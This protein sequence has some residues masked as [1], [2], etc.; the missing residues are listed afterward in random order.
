MLLEK[1]TTMI[2]V[3]QPWL[4]E[5]EE[6]YAIECVRSGWVSSAGRFVDEFEQQWAAY[7]HRAFGVSVNNGTSALQAAIEALDL[8][9]GDEV[10]LPSLT[11]ISCAQCIIQAG[12]TPVLVDCDPETWTMNPQQV[13]DRVTNHT[14]AVMAVHLYGHPVD[15][16]PILELCERHGLALIEDAAQA[17]GAECLVSDTNSDDSK[18]WQRCGSFGAMSCFSFYAN[19][20]ITT[21][22][23]GMVLTN[24][25]HL[26]KRLRNIRNLCFGQD[27]RFRHESLGHNF[28]LTNL[29]A[30]I[31]LAQF[32]RIEEILQR[33]RHIGQL[34]AHNL[35]DVSSISIQEN[36]PWAKS[37]YWMNGIVIE[38]KLGMNAATFAT[39]LR[40][41]GIDS[42]PFF[43]GMHDQP[44]LIA[45][46]LFSGESYPVTT[47]L[48]QQGLYLP[49]GAGLSDDQVAT[50]CQAV[51]E[52]A[53]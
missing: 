48:S 7:C 26:D 6:A 33:K 41:R 52:I 12:A 53:S 24:D 20:I 45:R 30:A 28:R 39:S 2:P 29:Q 8:S 38:E 43:T 27:Q 34:Y 19:K 14:R 51:Q 32:E 50:V 37:V 22:E 11:I 21:G 10:I 25:K 42:R 9:P 1:P 47:R 40:A 23:G 44:V 13:A 17:H 3:C 4:G 16:Q 49:S 35:K 36:R 5:R 15:M 31:G 46:G 18:T